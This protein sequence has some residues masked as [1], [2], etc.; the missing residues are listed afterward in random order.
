MLT[1]ENDQD[2][3][4]DEYDRVLASEM[5]ARPIYPGLVPDESPVEE[6]VTPIEVE[7]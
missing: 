1:N 6:E 2:D 3:G 7:V 5:D 4:L